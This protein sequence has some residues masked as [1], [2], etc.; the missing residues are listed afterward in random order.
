M[1]KTF[2]VIVLLFLIILVGIYAKYKELLVKQTEA[3]KFN[4]DFEFYQKDSILGTD[5][6]TIINK[7]ID[8]NEKWKIP[9]DEKGLY[10]AD[11]QNSIKIYVYMLINETTYPMESLKKS[12]LDEFT[13]YFGDIT[14]QC[15]DVKY[16]K[17][18]G[19]IAE[20]TFAARQV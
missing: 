4:R 1:K 9:K 17:T 13:R 10:L 2:F 3:Q 19:K 7:A 16:H 11:H 15:T 20:M 6:T 14:F 18:T 12:G 5:I 8:N